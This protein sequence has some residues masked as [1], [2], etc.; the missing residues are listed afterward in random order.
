MAVVW[1]VAALDRSPTE[2]SLSDVV[3][4]VHWTASDSETVGSGDDAVIHTGSSYGSVGLG[5]ANSSDFKAYAS[6]T[7]A[8]RQELLLKLQSRKH[9]HPKQV[10]LGSIL[11][12]N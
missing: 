3:K 11:L 1:K 7:E 8:K 4:T 6:I 9:R 12:Y 5:V 2:G 10:Y